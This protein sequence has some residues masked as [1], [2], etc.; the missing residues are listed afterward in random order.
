VRVA[1]MRAAALFLLLLGA[2]AW[3]KV[4]EVELEDGTRVH[5]EVVEKECTESTLVLVDLRTGARRQIP[6][7]RIEPSRAQALKVELGFE[8]AEAG[9]AFVTEAHEVRNRAGITFTGK[10]TNEAT[11]RAD[12]EIRLKTA[13]GERRIRLDDVAEGPDPVQVD[14]LLVYTPE[15]L[16]REHVRRHPAASPEDHFRTAELC[17]RW[18]ALERARTHYRAVLDAGGGKYNPETIQRLIERVEKQIGQQEARAKLQKIKQAIV[19]NR[20]DDA[21]RLSGEFRAANSDP[22]LLSDLDELDKEL[23]ER[24]K[25]YFIEQVKR[26]FLKEVK[27]VLDRKVRER[28]LALGAAQRYAGGDASASESATAEAFKAVA[29]RLGIEPREAFEFW[30]QRSKRT[31]Y[32]AFYRDGTFAVLPNLRDPLAKVQPPKP[33]AGGGKAKGPAPAMPKPHPMKNPEEWWKEKLAAKRYTE[34]R[35]FLFAW[36]AEKS[37]QVELLEPKDETC[38]ICAGKGYTAQQIQTPQGGV[39]FFDRCQACYA[40]TFKRVVQFR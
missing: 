34:A 37:G 26:E 19:F 2:L 31:V 36:W 5:G 17:R 1:E 32:K 14:S 27:T 20:F 24:R 28:D 12:G 39:A 23:A 25:A 9:E 11:H 33:P 21:A 35:D 38:D 3:A 13:D 29:A 15:E 7:T 8:V 18:G 10:W 30:N 6:W 22:D 16:Y 4:V 40:A